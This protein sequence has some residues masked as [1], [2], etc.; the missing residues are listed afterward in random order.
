MMVGIYLA[1]PDMP[2]VDGIL[3]TEFLGQFSVSIDQHNS[4]LTLM[5][6]KSLKTKKKWQ[7]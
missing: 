2:G 7:D 1:L 5:P 6:H 3:G 4:R